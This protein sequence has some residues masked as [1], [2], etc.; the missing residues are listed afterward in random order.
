MRFFGDASGWARSGQW[1][2]AQRR[3][4]GR[5]ETWPRLPGGLYYPK[6]RNWQAD[7]GHG[8]ESLSAH[9]DS[10]EGAGRKSWTIGRPRF[11]CDVGVPIERRVAMALKRSTP[12]AW[13]PKTLWP[14]RSVNGNGQEWGM[15]MMG[16]RGER[17][18]AD[19]MVGEAA[20]GPRGTGA[21]RALTRKGVR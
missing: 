6:R 4:H 2:G 7:D 19:D 3:H 18:A 9:S 5:G 15:Q 12:C 14:P 1:P 21:P 13:E 10:V 20:L 8:R 16:E 17:S 11:S